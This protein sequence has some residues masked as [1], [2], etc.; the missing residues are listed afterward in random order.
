M[1]DWSQGDKQVDFVL[2][3]SELFAQSREHLWRTLRV[4]NIGD[5][6]LFGLLDDKVDLCR[7]IIL[8]QLIKAIVEICGLIIFQL[9]VQNSM[10]SA[11][12]SSSVVAKPDI[13][14]RLGVFESCWVFAVQDER[15]RICQKSVLYHDSRQLQSFIFWRLNP[16]HFQYVAVLSFNLIFWKRQTLGFDDL[17]YGLIFSRIFISDLFRV[18]WLIFL[19]PYWIYERINHILRFF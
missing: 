14:P 2:H 18:L 6:V 16:M 10:L 8:T 7:H 9:N 4:A 19:L 3:F 5:F 13:V 1:N 11:I 17:L 15:L 12:S